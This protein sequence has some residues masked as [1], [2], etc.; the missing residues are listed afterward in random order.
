MSNNTV[1][2]HEKT[3]DLPSHCLSFLIVAAERGV[4]DTCKEAAEEMGFRVRAVE[5]TAAALRTIETHPVDLALLDWRLAG[6]EGMDLLLKLRH[7]HPQTEVAILTANATADFVL[8]AMKCGAFDFLRKPFYLNELRALLERAVDHLQSSLESRVAREAL[9]SNTASPSLIGRS[10][11]MEKLHRIIAKVAPGRHP[12]LVLGEAGTGK[13]MVARAIHASGPYSDKP[14]VPVDCDSLAPM[15][16]E[17]ELFGCVKLA[18]SNGAK[19]REGVF[20]LA[21]G[22]TVFLNEVGK[23]SMDIQAKLVR[24]MQDKEIRAVGAAKAVPFEVRILA[25]SS[26]D[27]QAVMDQGTFRREL[28]FRLNVVNLR[29]PPLRERKEDIRLL[30]EHFLDGINKKLGTP[31]SLSPEAFRLLRAYSWPGNLHELE[32]CLQRAVALGQRCVLDVRDL[33][34]EIRSFKVAAVPSASR[35][36][37]GGII[38]LAEMEKHAIMTALEQLKGDKIMTAKLLGLGK[39]TLYRKLKEYGIAQP[40]ASSNGAKPSGVKH[41]E[42]R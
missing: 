27:L 23:L 34:A 10:R 3:A 38:S 7:D 21:Q 1:L 5:S 28:Y 39:T 6:A 9:R 13:E 15:L 33:P 16:M 24:A 22:G 20:S 12:V 36:V 32:S 29:L 17:S 4:R 19:P 18:S 26:L 2:V 25:A 37:R 35:V 14:F 8:A 31:L 42:A 11:E 30:I 41:M 40:V